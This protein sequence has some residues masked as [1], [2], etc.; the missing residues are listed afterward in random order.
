MSNLTDN[1]RIDLLISKL[2]AA[3]KRR[4]VRWAVGTFSHSGESVSAYSF[5]FRDEMCEISVTSWDSITIE[6]HTLNGEVSITREVRNH[7]LFKMISDQLGWPRDMPTLDEAIS[8][9]EKRWT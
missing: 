1:Q 7:A 4:E 3:T 8:H 9:L 6:L 2:I 5:R